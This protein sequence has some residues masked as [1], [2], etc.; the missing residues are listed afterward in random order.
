[1]AYRFGNSEKGSRFK[2]MLPRLGPIK[3][4]NPENLLGKDADYNAGKIIDI[5]S[6]EKNE[7]SEAVCLNSA[8]ALVI[9]S[10]SDTFQEAFE[11]SKKHLETGKA[12]THL[13]KIQTF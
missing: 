8:A 6:G 12:L 1:M 4:N 11:F 13:R 7:F 3:F 10:K 2:L 9:S 5:F